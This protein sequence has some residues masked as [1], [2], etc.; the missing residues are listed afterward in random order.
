MGYDCEP[1]S[2]LRVG[3]QAEPFYRTH[4]IAHLGVAYP[5]MLQEYL[6][7]LFDVAN[8]FRSIGRPI[9]R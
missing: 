4:V 7:C 2:K 9:S 6:N 1:K 8:G 5:A 3:M